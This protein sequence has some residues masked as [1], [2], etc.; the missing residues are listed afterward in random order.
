[1]SHEVPS[2]TPS[3]QSLQHHALSPGSQVVQ[4]SGE[5]V[6]RHDMSGS[7]SGGEDVGNDTVADFINGTVNDQYTPRGNWNDN[8]GMVTSEDIITDTP[9]NTRQPLGNLMYERLHQGGQHGL[10][11]GQLDG[12]KRGRQSSDGTESQI[13]LSKKKASSGS[14]NSHRS[15]KNSSA[16]Q[17][18]H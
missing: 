14:K 5:Q 17:R 1:M 8:T 16:G 2:G 12:R 10:H 13:P 18:S 9:D 6:V 7:L 4:S 11:N 15:S 3:S